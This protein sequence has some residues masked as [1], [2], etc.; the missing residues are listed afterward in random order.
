MNQIVSPKSYFWKISRIPGKFQ[1]D[2]HQEYGLDPRLQKLLETE[3]IWIYIRGGQGV[4][5]GVSCASFETPPPPLF[6]RFLSNK[7]RGFASF[8]PHSKAFFFEKFPKISRKFPEIFSTFSKL[9]KTI[10]IALKIVQNH[11]IYLNLVKLPL[12]TPK[13]F[14]FFNKNTLIVIINPDSFHFLIMS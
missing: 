6:I 5:P 11:Y 9:K 14:R 3:F 13:N 2:M 8:E 1:L 4:G 12:K 7:F 10:I